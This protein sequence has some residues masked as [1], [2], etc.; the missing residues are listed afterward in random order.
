MP[1]D[2]PTATF[3]A[4]STSTRVPSK[5][6]PPTAALTSTTPVKQLV[7]S[8]G[9]HGDFFSEGE[10]DAFLPPD[11]Y[12]MDLETGSRTAISTGGAYC[13][14]VWSPDGE[15]VLYDN[16]EMLIGLDGQLVPSQCASELSLMNADGSNARQLM[17]VP[18]PSAWIGHPIWSPDG[19]KIAVRYE[20]QSDY[21]IF[22][23]NS[24]GTGW[25]RLNN[26]DVSDSPT[27]WS[28]DG[29]W[30]IGGPPSQRTEFALEVQGDRRVPLSEL[31]QVQVYDQ[32]YYPWKVI[33]VP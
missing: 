24:D 16:V 20:Y 5:L 32:T 29:R 33:E 17:S 10:T 6:P 21:G 19:T 7:F 14:A 25:Q 30:I 1:T 8:E 4:T 26:S 23:V 31:G 3:T 12:V 11:I 22:I 28:T 15:L 13:W 2:T 9:C 27:Y 18:N